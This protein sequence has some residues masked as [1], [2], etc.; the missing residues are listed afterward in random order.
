MTVLT[1][2]NNAMALSASTLPIPRHAED[3]AI[4]LMLLP[5]DLDSLLNQVVSSLEAQ[6]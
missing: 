4:A 3:Q 1:F 6:Q 2:P 5:A